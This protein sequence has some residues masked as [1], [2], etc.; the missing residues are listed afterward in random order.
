MHFLLCTF[1]ASTLTSLPYPNE[2][3]RRD[4]VISQT[5]VDRDRNLTL[6]RGDQAPTREIF[7]V[8]LQDVNSE[9]MQYHARLQSVFRRVMELERR[10]GVVRG[11]KSLHRERIQLG[12]EVSVTG[13]R[14]SG[15]PFMIVLLALI[16]VIIPNAYKYAFST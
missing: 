8:S 10:L 1:V 14:T 5:R 4:D 16:T 15:F 12:L 11:D 2:V 7:D 3:H 9:S 6:Q 13:V